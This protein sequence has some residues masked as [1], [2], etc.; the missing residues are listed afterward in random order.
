MVENIT[1]RPISL[2][3]YSFGF[4]VI[5]KS[6]KKYIE[7]TWGW[8]TEFQKNYYRQNFDIMN[9][10]IIEYDKV[11]IGLFKYTEEVEKIYIDQIYILPKYQSKGIGSKILIDIIDIGKSKKKPIE[12]QVLKINLKGIK[13]YQKLCFSEYDQTETHIKMV[14]K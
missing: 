6:Y 9:L 2:R 7:K 10:C 14:L 5:K 12:L 4:F 3:D 8:N 1:I 11:R 13:F